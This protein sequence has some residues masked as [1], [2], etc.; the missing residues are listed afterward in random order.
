[1]WALA[2]R[3]ANEVEGAKL[4]PAQS[5][6][7]VTDIDRTP[8]TGYILTSLAEILYLEELSYYAA[9]DRRHVA[10]S[11]ERQWIAAGPFLT[12]ELS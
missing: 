2:T 10:R 1:M 6:R 8:K 11:R 3:P 9:F 4:F 7:P 5:I 12:I